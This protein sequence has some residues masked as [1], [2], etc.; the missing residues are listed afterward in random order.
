MKKLIYLIFLLG[1]S[2]SAFAQQI[3]GKVADQTGLP[4]P[5]VNVNS[6]SGK[7]AVTDIDGQFSIDVPSGE[8]LTFTMVGYLTKSAPASVNMV[9]SMP[10]EV[11]TLNEV[12]VVGYGTRKLGSITGSVSLIKSDEIV[13]TPAQS[14]IQAIQG[15]AAGVNIV[16]TDE[17]GANPTIRIRGLGTILAGRDPLYVIDGVEISALNGSS[18]LNGLNQ[19]DIESINVLKD[20]SSL[21]IYGQKGANGVVII[22][23]KRGKKGEPKVAINSFY[24]E[25]SVLKKV[26]MADAYRY[27]YYNN[28]ALGSTRFFN[29][30]Q[31]Y[32]TDW[33]EE[34][35]QVG[36]VTNNSVSV[37]GANESTNYSLGVSHYAEDGILIGTNYKRTNLFNK[38]EYNLGS[39][40]VKLRNFINLSTGT[41]TPKPLSA[42]TNAYKQAPIMPVVY[43]NGRWGAPII[44][45]TTGL[46]DYA[47]TR[48]NNVA[49]PV[50]QLFNTTEK[51]RY[52]TVTASL[53]L[54]FKLLEGLVFTSNFGGTAEY[55]KEFIYTPLRDQYLT[56]NPQ[57]TVADFEATFGEENAIRNN[58]LEQKRSDFFNWNWDNYLTYKKT[59]GRHDLT[60]VA[61]V[62][63]STIDN[64]EFL[65]A[66]RYNVP[67]KSD[68]WFL[69]LASDTSDA[70]P[71]DVIE[72]YHSTAFISLAYF[73]R[74]EYSFNDRYLL[75]GVVRREGLSPFIGD[76]KWATFPSISAGW[77]I[78]NE[79]FM[80]DL[81]FL[82]HLKIRGGYGE[83]GNGNG[84]AYNAPSYTVGKP[85]SFGGQIQPGTYKYSKPDPNLTWETMREFDFGLDFALLTNRLTGTF[86]IYDRRSDGIIL[87]VDPPAVLSEGKV[88]V[89]AG[90]VTNK[91]F[92][93]TLRWDDTIGENFRYWI[94]GNYSS[95]KNAVSRSDSDFFRNFP[96]A[97]SLSNGQSTKR[98]YLDAP[99]GSFFVW[100]QIGYDSQG[101]PRYNDMV[102]GVP[103]LTDR[104]RINA[105]TYIPKYT[106]GINLGAT[107]KG[108]DFSVDAY[109]VGGNKIYNGKKAQRFAGEN[110]EFDILDNL[111]TPNNPTAEN[112]AP[113][114]EVP[115]ASTYYIEDGAYLRINNIT[116]GYTLP[117]M[118]DKLERVRLYVTATNPFIFTEYSG[119]SPEIAGDDRGNPLRG[120][121]IELDAYP[122]NKTFLVGANINF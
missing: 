41:K 81:T 105:G 106:Y 108:I 11:N 89:N 79:S 25:K 75:T 72:N 32:N 47:G 56:S 61:G 86:D 59:V 19:N 69:D 93:M 82:S 67:E 121:G 96:N 52:N 104:D 35:T 103:G 15:K 74:F 77:V 39:D 30:N 2:A 33:F 65:R 10:E 101:A 100:E 111:W 5:G 46:P 29:Q 27:T 44:N 62:S 55:T 84:T 78:S 24:G 57:A 16:A 102:D 49:N 110:I 50:A 37:T 94:G 26:K 113:F 98:V 23:T 68:Y 117:K 80:K 4:L 48:Y 85:Y 116:L 107:Y 66:T 1:C 54:D 109:G 21:A 92:E 38:I 34:I 112:P 91:G 73:G 28:A 40:R 8:R 99:I 114:N 58:K 83:V 95:N 18:P 14:A 6:T 36:A 3:T 12:V 115:R 7:S 9:I 51:S 76:K 60:L 122:T 70:T 43:P 45:T 90:E 13:K 119:Y 17:P 97:G 20:A 71:S 31:A 22:T 118:F 88:Y 120:A 42:F 63:R 87:E 53:G 64:Y